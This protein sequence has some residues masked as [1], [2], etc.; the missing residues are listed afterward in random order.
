M[1]VN[2]I[3]VGN[4]IKSI[5]LDQ[6]ATMEEFGK[7]FN[8]SKGTVNNWEKGRNLPNKENLLKIAK[9][10]NLSVEQ[11]LYGSSARSR[12][13]WDY[14]LDYMEKTREELDEEAFENTKQAIDS[15]FFIRLDLN[16]I[17]NLYNY[18]LRNPIPVKDL[19]GMK[20]FYESQANFLEE[21]ISSLDYTENN[22]DMIM[23][24]EIEANF[25]RRYIDRIDRYQKTGIWAEDYLKELEKFKQSQE[26]WT[27][28]TKK[29]KSIPLPLIKTNIINLIEP[30]G[31]GVSSL[32]T[33]EDAP[34]KMITTSLY[35]SWFENAIHSIPTRH[36][37]ENILRK[38][39]YGRFK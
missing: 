17:I 34:D 7:A 30:D 1:E 29:G 38:E 31:A 28:A 10:G 23:D 14:I 8:T 19:N 39:T 11:L 5:R 21:Y 36:N 22:M 20:K 12:Y 13:N 6:G 35:H 25:N 4:R 2:N 18:N 33:I 3:E 32:H 16:D 37:I 15:A 9:L 26:N 24:L 27:I